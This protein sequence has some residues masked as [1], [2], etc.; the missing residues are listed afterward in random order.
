MGSVEGMGDLAEAEM[1]RAVRVLELARFRMDQH[2]RAFG[3]GR[4]DRDLAR[5]LRDALAQV[6]FLEGRAAQALLA[7]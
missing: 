2:R 5:R 7:A 3:D 6:W 1:K 4:V